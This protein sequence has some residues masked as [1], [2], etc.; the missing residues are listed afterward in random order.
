MKLVC[1]ISVG[2]LTVWLAL[3]KLLNRLIHYMMYIPYGDKSR[4]R[5]YLF[6]ALLFSN[7]SGLCGCLQYMSALALPTLQ[8]IKHSFVVIE[9]AVKKAAAAT[10]IGLG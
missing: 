7:S 3:K 9:P 1:L 10:K 6:T 4:N 8:L 2:G 5:F